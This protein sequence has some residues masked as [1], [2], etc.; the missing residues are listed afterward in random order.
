MARQPCFAVFALWGIV[1][2]S[3]LSLLFPPSG[4]LE[5]AIMVG[6]LAVSGI[7]IAYDTQNLKEGYFQNEGDTRSLAVM[8][9][10]GALGFFISF[11]NIFTILMSMLSSD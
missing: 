11:Y 10:F 1:G 8:T 5:V 3:L 2:V 4:F 7:L 6:V 9:N